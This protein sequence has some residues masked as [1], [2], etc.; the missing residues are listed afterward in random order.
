MLLTDYCLQLKHLP[1]Q[2]IAALFLKLNDVSYE[3]IASFLELNKKNII[4]SIQYALKGDIY[5]P[6]I[7]S[8]RTQKLSFIDTLVLIT[9]IDLKIV[10]GD[11]ISID[12]ACNMA[13]DLFKKRQEKALIYWGQW[14]HKSNKECDTY[15]DIETTYMNN[16][17]NDEGEFSGTQIESI[18][19][20]AGFRIV[21][22]RLIERS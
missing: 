8:G 2:Q 14:K 1:W 16:Y 15:E 21:K 12:D 22:G 6:N 7:R 18:L 5:V 13:T 3:K 19:K 4:K 9:E 10:K 20:D 17:F 11:K